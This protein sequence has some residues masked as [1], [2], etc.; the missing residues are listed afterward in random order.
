MLMSHPYTMVLKIEIKPLLFEPK[1][2]F[3][4]FEVYDDFGLIRPFW[5]EESDEIGAKIAKIVCRLIEEAFPM[6]IKIFQK[7]SNNWRI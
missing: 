6:K 5:I 3:G 4:K 2:F 1:T 7:S